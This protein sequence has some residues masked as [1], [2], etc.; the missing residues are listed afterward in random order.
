MKIVFATVDCIVAHAGQRV[1]LA[2]GEAW[3]AEDSLVRAHP[4]MFSETPAF[5]RR[6]DGSGVVAAVVEQATKA[7]GERRG[8]LR[9]GR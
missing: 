9:R 2:P 6:T 5:A 8:V 7:P 4:E 3:D 1:R